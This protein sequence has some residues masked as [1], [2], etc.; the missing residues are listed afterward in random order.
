MYELVNRLKYKVKLIKVNYCER[1]V[2]SD[3]LYINV[4]PINGNSYTYVYFTPFS[5]WGS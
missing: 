2:V 3:F 5:H 1:H 4:A